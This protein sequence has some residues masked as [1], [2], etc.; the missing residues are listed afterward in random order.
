MIA[1][2]FEIKETENKG[3]GLFA[4]N[5]IP[6][7][8]IIDFECKECKTF[9]PKDLEKLPEFKRTLILENSYPQLDG[10]LTVL[11]D[12]ARYMNHSCNANVLDS[13]EDFDIVVRDIKK[14][15]ESTY[16]YRMFYEHP[17]KKTMRC[18]CGE[19]TCCKIVKSVHP[20]PNVLKRIWSRKIISALELTKK[21]NQPLKEE[22]LKTS[23]RFKKF[24]I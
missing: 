19:K 11:C 6:K 15:E 17:T 16:D 14:G 13:G 2:I 20:T 23:N 3:K 8:T 24:L 10:S 12:E 5:F 22:L 18:N 7:G 4:K 1:K 9:S 21:V